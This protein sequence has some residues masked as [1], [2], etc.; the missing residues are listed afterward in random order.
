MRYI[1]LIVLCLRLDDTPSLR[2][3]APP[4]RKQ[5]PGYYRT[6]IGALSLPA[7]PAA[8]YVAARRSRRRSIARCPGSVHLWSRPAVIRPPLEVWRPG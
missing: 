7:S 3:D 2:G 6:P 8:P 4:D 5:Y 1:R